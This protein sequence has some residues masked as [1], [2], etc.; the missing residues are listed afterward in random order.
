MLGK[1]DMCKVV[2]RWS[3]VPAL[4]DAWCLSHP[5]TKLARTC[6]GEQRVVDKTPARSGPTGLAVRFA[7]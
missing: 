7:R 3:G 4:S 6:K 2:Y 1:C 5:R